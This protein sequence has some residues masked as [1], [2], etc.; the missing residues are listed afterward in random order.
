MCP[1]YHAAQSHYSTISAACFII[2]ICVHNSVAVLSQIVPTTYSVLK[3][4]SPCTII[5]SSVF[6]SFAFAFFIKGNEHS[7][8]DAAF[9]NSRRLNS[10]E[11]TE[12]ETLL[13]RDFNVLTKISDEYF[14]ACAPRVQE[15]IMLNVLLKDASAQSC[16]L[17]GHDMHLQRLY[18]SY[19]SKLAGSLRCRAEINLYAAENDLKMSKKQANMIKN[20]S[21]LPRSNS[22]PE[23]FST[24]S[25]LDSKDKQLCR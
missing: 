12:A 8:N 6:F 22:C 11:M 4:L 3:K 10:G 13:H 21:L 16:R 23:I 20:N 5:I 9:K 19:K 7:L 24:K 25:V 2:G 15:I 14:E 17:G 18:S 1:E